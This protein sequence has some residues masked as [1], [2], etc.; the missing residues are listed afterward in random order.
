MP[1]KRC[2]NLQGSFHAFFQ[3][4]AIVLGDNS[5]F[6][7]RLTRRCAMTCEYCYMESGPNA[8]QDFD[9]HRLR[10]ILRQARRI[11][12]SWVS[13]SGGDPLAHPR[14]REAMR[15]VEETGLWLFVETGGR[16]VTEEV[17]DWFA[18][19]AR[20]RRCIVSVGLDSHEPG[21]HDRMRGKGSHA[22]AVRAIGLLRER[23]VNVHACKVLSSADFESDFNLDQLLDFCRRIGI[24]RIDVTRVV[25]LGRG[26]N[27]AL[28]LSREQVEE[29]R[30]QLV[31]RE[32]Y[33]PFVYSVDFSRLRQFSRCARLLGDDTGLVVNAD[34]ISPCPSLPE[35]VLGKP[36]DLASIVAC[37]IQEK[38]EHLRQ[39]ATVGADPEAIWGCQ[40]C[41]PAFLQLIS[42]VGSLLAK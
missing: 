22:A 31:T 21:V 27:R 14:F 26:D 40:E 8:A 15:L 1:S 13:I 11:G 33:G 9:L 12:Y 34:H 17:A 2:S 35:I 20:H 28:W 30:R 24:S 23:G 3:R 37:R 19:F 6:C 39:A 5:F 38:L 4:R 7:I 36:E 29:A 25:P 16:L 41:R 32:D 18:E 10:D 42:Q